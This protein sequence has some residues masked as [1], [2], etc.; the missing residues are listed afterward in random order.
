MIEIA[1]SKKI[2]LKEAVERYGFSKQFFYQRTS[3]R[4]IPYEKIAG[5]I[6]FDIEKLDAW[7]A[8]QSE[9]FEPIA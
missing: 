7:F 2:T 6:F 4:G 5:K 3:E 1:N 8:K 9:T